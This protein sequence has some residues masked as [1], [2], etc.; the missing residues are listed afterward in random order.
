MCIHTEMLASDFWLG[1]LLASKP[2]GPGIFGLSRSSSAKYDPEGANEMATNAVGAH[3]IWLIDTFSGVL[4][5][6][7]GDL[8]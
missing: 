5:G 4:S 1:Q 3:R 6:A 2:C 7:V 8:R